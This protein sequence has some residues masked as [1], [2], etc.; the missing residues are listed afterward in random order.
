MSAP[1]T[2]NAPETTQNDAGAAPTEGGGASPFAPLKAVPAATAPGSEQAPAAP[3]WAQGLSA[4][5]LAYIGSKGWDKDGK[6]PAD[7]LRSYRNLERL[8]GVDAERLVK[9]PDWSKP[10]EVAEYRQRIGVPEA[11]DKYENHEVN[12]PTGLLDASAIAKLSHRI[13]ANQT[14]HTELLNG[15]GELLTEIFQ[16]EQGRIARQQAIELQN[17][18]REVG[19]NNLE[20]FNQDFL[21]AREKFKEYLPDDVIETIGMNLEVPFRKL[22]A[23]VGKAMREGTRAADAGGSSTSPMTAMQAEAELEALQKDSSFFQRLQSGDAE[24][25]RRL[26]ELQTIAFGP[27]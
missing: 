26:A 4:D 9:I 25:K 22:M 7:V 16:A 15:T 14:Q 6:G 3:A 5:E 27:H 21:S 13:G 2:E 1:A 20:A 8:R 12:L 23:A 17:L 19:A 11:P 18:A 24:A 10:E